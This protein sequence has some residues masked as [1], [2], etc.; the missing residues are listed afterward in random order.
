MKKNNEFSLIPETLKTGGKEQLLLGKMST[1]GKVNSWSQIFKK[2]LLQL[3][4]N[5]PSVSAVPFKSSV[6]SP[7]E[8]VLI[9]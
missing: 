8:P 2:F 5:D 7:W 4:Y 6:T 1:M 9:M 3:I